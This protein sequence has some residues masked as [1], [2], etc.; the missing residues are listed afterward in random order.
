MGSKIVGLLLAVSVVIS[1]NCISGNAAQK[2]ASALKPAIPVVGVAYSLGQLFALINTSNP[3]QSSNFI[4]ATLKGKLVKHEAC[5]PSKGVLL[6]GSVSSD[7]VN[8]GG[9]AINKAWIQANQGV[10]VQL[11]ADNMLI[12]YLTQKKR[13]TAVKSMN[14]KYAQILL[15]F[16][17]EIGGAKYRFY[18][19]D[20]FPGKIQGNVN[21]AAMILKK[22]DLVRTYRP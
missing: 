9:V 19:N 6:D 17:L 12:S 3:A 22:W 20:P 21:P 18:M 15:F 2:A 5:W 11:Q 8:F 1:Q 10:Q 13:L 7:R 4:M 16:V 14:Q